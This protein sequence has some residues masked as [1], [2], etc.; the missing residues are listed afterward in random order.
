MLFNAFTINPQHKIQHILLDFSLICAILSFATWSF[1]YFP[2]QIIPIGPNH[3]HYQIAFFG[4]LSLFFSFTW[5]DAFRK[6]KKMMITISLLCLWGYIITKYN[7][8]DC[9][10]DMAFNA[11]LRFR[12]WLLL[13]M[14][15][16][17]WIILLFSL[18]SREIGKKIFIYSVMAGFAFNSVH[19]I[20]EAFANVGFAS[21]KEFLININPYVRLE[22]IAQGW[23]PPPYYEGRIRGFYAEPSHLACGVLPVMGICWYFFK[24]YSQKLWLLPIIILFAIFV[25]GN[26]FS[27]FL[28][29]AGFFGMVILHAIATRFGFAK[30]C[31]FFVVTSGVVIGGSVHFINNSDMGNRIQDTVYVS[32]KII[33]HFNNMHDGIASEPFDL[34]KMPPPIHKIFNRGTLAWL[35][36][37]LAMRHPLGVGI[38]LKTKY[39]MVLESSN[40]QGHELGQW[41]RQKHVPTLTE[42]N[43]YSTEL[44]IIGVVLLSLIIF[45]TVAKMYKNYQKTHDQFILSMFFTFFG[46]LLVFFTQRVDTTF[47]FIYY[48]AFLY[49][50]SSHEIPANTHTTKQA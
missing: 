39:F 30:A 7:S 17:A 42:Y 22:K 24:K 2:Y 11:I 46:F 45:F 18:I 26:T 25:W 4:L 27:G 8:L 31:L 6:H 32:S 12:G 3:L 36:F 16:F 21:A 1:N 28:A 29:M 15:Y 19:M 43:N 50:Y 23:W 5:F 33:E 10:P 20:L 49:A 13:P 40:F 34:D 44:G 41:V 38:G 35:D 14:L 47:A 48:L 37:N 9:S